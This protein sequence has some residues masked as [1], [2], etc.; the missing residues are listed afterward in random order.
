MSYQSQRGLGIEARAQLVPAHITSGLSKE[1]LHTTIQLID[2]AF[3]E[4][5]RT[6]DVSTLSCIPSSSQSV[7]R[8]LAKDCGVLSGLLIVELVFF[9]YDQS[10]K[11]EW[12]KKDGDFVDV[13][14]YFGT[15]TGS[16]QSLLTA[17][18]L[19]LNFM[20]RMS[21]I[22]SM[23]AELMSAI[24]QGNPQS[25]TRLLDTR[26]T[27][28]GLRLLDKMA[29]R[30][31]G[32]TNHRIGL[33]DM[34]M[35]KDNHITAAGSITQAI[36]QVRDYMKQHPNLA[37]PIEVETRTVDEV[38]EVI[39]VINQS[40]ESDARIQR[41]MLDNMV[42]VVRDR[43]NA[44]VKNVD[45]SLLE[46]AVDLLQSDQ[47]KQRVESEASGNVTRET[48]GAIGRTGVDFIS[49]GAITH[50]VK[51]LDISLKIQ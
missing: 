6:G 14:T 23:V 24:Q 43:P 39:N 22:A 37:V 17:E 29:V 1:E 40:T 49:V 42:R 18:R 41:V 11:V 5:I 27:A 32:G 46:Q 38:R 47:V 12:S 15:V 13:G 10:I 51:A 3:D 26:K 9:Q 25:K 36:K 50:S 28:P 4:D 21:G 45:V 34:V 31:G 35:I 30:H 8:F 7:A 19:A 44:P 48:I 33:F 2:A 20:Q 16:S